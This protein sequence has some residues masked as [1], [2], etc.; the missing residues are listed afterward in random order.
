MT[1][2]VEKLETDIRERFAKLTER[3]GNAIET[4]DDEALRQEMAATAADMLV[5][6]ALK[7]Q[8]FAFLDPLLQAD[9]PRSL[10][11]AHLHRVL[12]AFLTKQD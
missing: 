10:V 9:Q 12:P 7:N 4:A 3:I 2:A 11:S 6:T 8:D 5:L 1:T